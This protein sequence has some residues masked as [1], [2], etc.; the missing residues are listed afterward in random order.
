MLNPGIDRSLYVNLA[1]KLK[2]GEN[3][4]MD[5]PKDFEGHC[6]YCGKSGKKATA[7]NLNGITLLS[8]DERWICDS[9]LKR[10]MKNI[11]VSL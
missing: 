10:M 6:D 7:K 9:C 3:G 2:E 5:K 4:K 8:P 1:K 11:P